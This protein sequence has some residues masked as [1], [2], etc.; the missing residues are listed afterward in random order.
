[1]PPRVWI[2]P[3]FVQRCVRTPMHA[4]TNAP[5]VIPIRGFCCCL[6]PLSPCCAQTYAMHMC[7][8][9]HAVCRLA[10]ICLQGH[11]V[12]QGM[13]MARGDY[14]LFMDADGATRFTDLEKLEAQLSR[15]TLFC[16]GSCR[17]SVTLAGG[18]GCWCRRHAVAVTGFRPKKPC[19]W[20][21][22]QVQAV[23]LRQL[24]LGKWVRC[25]SATYYVGRALEMEAVTD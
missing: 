16:G 9:A 12:R 8:Q 4:C 21:S 11:A 6:L 14:C 1:M 13:R 20:S 5:L 2:I 10:C 19:R 17:Y 24:Q 23:C 18:A 22:R 25:T 7:A 15:C 3:N